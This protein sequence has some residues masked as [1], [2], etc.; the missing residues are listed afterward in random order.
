MIID[1]NK[2]LKT[3]ELPSKLAAKAKIKK[4]GLHFPAKRP[5][6]L[7]RIITCLKRMYY[8][9]ILTYG[10]C[11]NKNQCNR[12]F[13]KT[14]YYALRNK[15]DVITYIPGKPIKWAKQPY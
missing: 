4:I 2:T 5:C 11:N 7:Q 15:L 12:Q 6:L 1:N 3:L 13:L 10:I 9:V 14:T 8:F